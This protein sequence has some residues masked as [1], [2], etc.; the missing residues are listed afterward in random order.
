[1][2]EEHGFEPRAGAQFQQHKQATDHEQL[3][4]PGEDGETEPDGEQPRDEDPHIGDK[5]QD[6]GQKPPQDGVRQPDHEQPEA[7]Q[8]P[9]AAIDERLHA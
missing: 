2:A 7:K 5:P 6:G 8:E 9:K 1:V 4:P 3:G